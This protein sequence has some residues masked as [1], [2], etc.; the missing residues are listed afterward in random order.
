VVEAWPA[1]KL[2]GPG[3]MKPPK[4]LAGKGGRTD[5]IRYAPSYRGRVSVVTTETSR[6][7]DAWTVADFLGRRWKQG[8]KDDGEPS[9]RVRNA[10]AALEKAEE[11]TGKPGETL[12]PVTDGSRGS[13]RGVLPYRSDPQFPGVQ[14]APGRPQGTGQDLAPPSPGR[15]PG[16]SCSIPGAR[17]PPCRIPGQ[18]GRLAGLAGRAS[19]SPPGVLCGDGLPRGR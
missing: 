18:T 8:G 1:G 12:A 6:P 13:A 5:G 15:L 9:L 2:D 10:L 4:S 7:Y 19:L 17:P 14:D 11:A 3:G 16:A